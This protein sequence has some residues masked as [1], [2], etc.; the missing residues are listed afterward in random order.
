MAERVT[1][2]ILQR[3]RLVPDGA[4]VIAGVSGGQDSCALLIALAGLREAW[5]F[6]LEAAHVHH[7]MRAE[8]DADLEFVADLCAGLGV[9]LHVRRADVPAA[10]RRLHIAEEE[11]GRRARHAFFDALADD[12]RAVR[13]ALGHTADDRVE[14]VM[15]NILRGAGSDGLGAMPP[16]SGRIIRPL[17]DVQREDTASYCRS[18]G[19]A[20]RHDATNDEMHHRRNRVR[21]ELLPLLEAGF[22]PRVR[23]ALLRLAQLASADA[24]VVD[25]LAREVVD[26]AD[27]EADRIAF[28]AP[29]LANVE[30][31]VAR[32]AV[33][34][35]VRR[36]RGDVQDVPHEAVEGA[37]DALERSGAAWSR[38]LPPGGTRLTVR[39]GAMRVERVA[40]AAEARP[41]RAEIPVPGEVTVP[42]WG[43]R[44]TCERVD[45]AP[46]ATDPRAGDAVW[47][48]E[49]AVQVPLI[50]RSRL[51]GDRVRGVAMPGTRKLQDI[52]VDR[53]VPRTE[54]DRVP[55]VCDAAGVVW[56][57]GHAIDQR[58][59]AVPGDAAVVVRCAPV[60]NPA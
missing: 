44:F 1:T 39:A 54:R 37:L 20:Y 22:N 26:A 11:A 40:P 48:R 49:C 5:R 38:M 30:R 55:V 32:R 8:G 58:A 36:V 31:A 19:I 28:T 53:K 57:V 15:L 23:E 50:V 12:D 3:R 21:T 42:E 34:E 4:R 60:A 35:A 41:V 27:C 52:L 10:A 7:G 18:R 9:P 2:A 47:L 17:I 16:Q 25:R 6:D 45:A 59:A 56:V 51:P 24:A 14:T 43:L 29:A 13:I 46:D 33:R